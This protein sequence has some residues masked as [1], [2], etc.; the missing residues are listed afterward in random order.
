ML[1][2]ALSNGACSLNG[3]VDRYALSCFVTL[4]SLGNIISTELVSSV[5]NSK[6]RGVYA[7][8]NDILEKNENSEFY[9]KYAHVIDDFYKMM[10]LYKILK[11]KS[12]AKGAME[13]ESDEA[14]II[15]DKRGMPI[16]IV[17]RERGESER[18]I[19]RITDL[20]K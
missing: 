5:I 3:G 17:K 7:E 2:E 16:D 14:K 1:P 18:L 19:E 13:L 9:Q 15:L 10:E 20:L 4:D 11:A 12:E 8:L 6:V